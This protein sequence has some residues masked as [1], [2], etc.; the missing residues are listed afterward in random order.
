MEFRNILSFEIYH[1]ALKIAFC[2]YSKFVSFMASLIPGPFYLQVG[3]GMED[4]LDTCSSTVR[5]LFGAW[6]QKSLTRKTMSDTT[7]TVSPRTA[8]GGGG[9]GGGGGRG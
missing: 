5:R 4:G 3:S 7:I 9:G 1:F 6:P 2:Q 8:V